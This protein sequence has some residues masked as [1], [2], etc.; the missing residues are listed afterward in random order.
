ME[1]YDTDLREIFR[2]GMRLSVDDCCEIGLRSLKRR[3][4]NQ[5]VIQLAHFFEP[6]N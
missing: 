1:K 6:I 3:H 5:F 4:G 2:V